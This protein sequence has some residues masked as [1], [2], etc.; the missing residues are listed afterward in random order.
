MVLMC[1]LC[2]VSCACCICLATDDLS[3]AAAAGIFT[4]G[5]MLMLNEIRQAVEG[6]RR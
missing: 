2:A 6:R 1:W 3:L 5:V 4:Y